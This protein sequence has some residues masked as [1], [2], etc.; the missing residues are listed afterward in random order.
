VALIV[1]RS[2]TGDLFSTSILPL[3]PSLVVYI[4][5]FGLTPSLN[6][7]IRITPHTNP[8]ATTPERLSEMNGDH[9]NPETERIR[10]IATDQE[11]EARLHEAGFNYWPLDRDDQPTVEAQC[12]LC[13]PQPETAEY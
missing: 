4:P 8:S 7:R 13:D 3:S 12:T 11:F 10:V 2:S 6:S 5:S 9:V 1:E